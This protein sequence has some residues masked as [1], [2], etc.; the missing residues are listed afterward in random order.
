MAGVLTVEA[1][2]VE[3]PE[4]PKAFSMLPKWYTG[5]PIED[6]ERGR[7]MD[8]VRTAL[9]DYPEP[10]AIKEIRYG[11]VMVELWPVTHTLAVADHLHSKELPVHIP[12]WFY[13]HFPWIKFVLLS[14]KGKSDYG[15]QTRIHWFC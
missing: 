12:R 7:L 6:S 15:R 10:R 11:C 2:E 3:T 1:V 4:S 9:L 5:A 8:E 13:Y 14:T